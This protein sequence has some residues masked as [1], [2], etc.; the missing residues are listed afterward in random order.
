MNL[1]A[2]EIQVVRRLRS[3]WHVYTCD[4]LP[5]LYVAS[6]DDKKAYNDLPLAIQT[7]FKLDHGVS[8]SVH[9]KTDYASFMAQIEMGRRAREAVEART[10]DMMDSQQDVLT[11]MVGSTNNDSAAGSH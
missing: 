4:T 11:F 2:F 8:V 7:L 9:H 10:R 5:G 1:I 6:Q 3:G